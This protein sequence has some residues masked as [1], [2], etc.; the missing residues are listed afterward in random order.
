[1]R[2]D[3]CQKEIMGDTRFCPYCGMLIVARERPAEP[4]S[5]RQTAGVLVQ[6][7]P[8][9]LPPPDVQAAE[10][11]TEPS[12]ATWT[13]Y[14]VERETVSPPQE[15]EPVPAARSLWEP[16][17]PAKP[18]FP[19]WE[20]SEPVRPPVDPGTAE[21]T[22]QRRGAI[23][24]VDE[25]KARPLRVGEFFAMEL[26]SLIP[27]IGFVVLCIWALGA[28]MNPN[29]AHYARARLLMTLILTILTLSCAVVLLVLAAS[30][31]LL[32]PEISVRFYG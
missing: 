12:H 10:E 2:C 11:Q 32:I 9:S 6:E 23:S 24:L 29:R 7:R 26:V 1:M 16:S 14:A 18:A 28:R 5:E 15:P 8:E 30:G 4:E 3:N 21:T 27:V 22:G 19:S 13:P 31:V 20:T 17:E 25:E